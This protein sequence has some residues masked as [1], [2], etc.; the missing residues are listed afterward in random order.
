MT[1]QTA[2][3]IVVSRHRAASL[4]LCLL[5]LS[6]QD[7]PSFEVIVV[8][9]P[10]ALA[11]IADFDVK[12]VVFDEANI[13]A[14][15]NA[16]LAVAAGQVVAFIDDDAV[17]EPTWLTRLVAPFSDFGVMASAGFVRGRNG[18]SRQWG[19]AWVD[20]FGE[21]HAFDLPNEGA[22]F[23]PEMNRV[24]KTQG[25]NCA[26]RREALLAIGGF[27][28]AYRFYHDETDVNLRMRARTAVVPMAQVVHGY[29]QSERR[30]ADR[31]PMSL[32][33]IGASCAVF[34]RRH[35]PEADQA[36][37]FETLRARQAERVALH[38]AAGRIDVAQRDALLVGF[39]LGWQAGLV[40]PLTALSP[41]RA[42]R[43][44]LAPLQGTGPKPG[45]VLAGRFWQIGSL[46][47]KGR[48][49]VREG[50][51]VT[52]LCLRW[53]ARPH[54][55]RFDED[56]YWIQTGGVFGRSARDGPKVRLGTL[57]KR[58]AEECARWAEVRP[59]R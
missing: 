36:V 21:D 37:Q 40:R 29:A 5:A 53:T 27:D 6:Q 33:E 43:A 52:I 7:H 41:L 59:L 54:W 42:T 13:S 25:T 4:R 12:T 26:F 10:Q 14:A 34:M 24:I 18:I 19:A 31:V 3:V 45:R 28:P 50:A 38:H 11:A 46:K 51:I 22:V 55:Q 48:Q 2:S 44:P 15:R 32:V 1:G 39:D 58:L 16:G 9:D 35:A 56:G 57:K 49:A 23:D 30:R 20:R 47:A 8:A 17:A